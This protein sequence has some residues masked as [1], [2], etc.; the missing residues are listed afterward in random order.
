M[1]EVIS[2]DDHRPHSSRYV[3]CMACAH[4]WVAVAPATTLTLECPSCGLME[5]ESVRTADLSWLRR[6]MEC[7]PMSNKQRHKRTMVMLNAKRMGL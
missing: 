5:G 6:F 3:A 1:S 4:D 7:S 2:L